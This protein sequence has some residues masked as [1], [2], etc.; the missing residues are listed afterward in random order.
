MKVLYACD[1]CGLREIEVEVEARSKD[2]DVVHFVE[3]VAAACA[4]DHGVR[5]PDCHPEKF[6]YVKIPVPPGDNARIGDETKN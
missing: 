5:S 2:E 3:R 4:D 6:T 1:P